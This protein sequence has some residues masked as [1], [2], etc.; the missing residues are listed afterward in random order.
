ML[1]T[2]WAESPALAIQLLARFQSAKLA[3]DVRWLLI[4][5]PDKALGQPDALQILLGETLPNDISFQL[6][7]GHLRMLRDDI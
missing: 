4:N 3:Y 5:F 2:A 7:V 6:K 1:K